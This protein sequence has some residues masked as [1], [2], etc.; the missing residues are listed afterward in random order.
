MIDSNLN[1]TTDT[2][3]DYAL[4]YAAQDLQVGPLAH[5]EPIPGTRSLRYLG[6]KGKVPVLHLATHGVDDFTT[7][8]DLIRR[9]WSL[10]EWNIGARLPES[11][12]ALDVDGPDR[13][14][15]P[16]TGMDGLAE[17]AKIHGPDLIPETYMQTTGSGG[18][19]YLFRRPPGKL[20]KK[21]LK[22]YGLDFKDCGGYIVM[23]PSIHPDSLRVY[24]GFP[25]PIAAT[26]EWLIRM[27]IEPPT[28][29]PI[30]P[31]TT[32][33]RM[34]GPSIADAFCETTTW[35]DVLMPYGWS[36]I[37]NDTDGDGARWLHPTA[38]SSC[39]ATIRHGKL[40]VYSSNTPFE[41]T[42]SG[43]AVG[44]TRFKAAA[45]LSFP[46]LSEKAAMSEFARQLRTKG[47][48]S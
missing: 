32:W 14:P 27:I 30:R 35:A 25:A 29:T 39:S 45:V 19:H 11:V 33:D 21:N 43:A 17:L 36:A 40:F 1:A 48:A 13:N 28:V 24:E 5:Y 3:V 18:R 44:Y 10:G 8:P 41:T 6:P 47:I 42:S 26:P 31:T 16:G 15:H 9:W 2:M 37:G 38:T 46:H 23:A 34:A 12:I 4:R 20:I 22:P 7:D